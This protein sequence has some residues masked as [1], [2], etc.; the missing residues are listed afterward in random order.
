MT[1]D[2]R[3]VAAK[4]YDLQPSPFDGKDIPFYIALIPSPSSAV[5]E[6]GCGT[7]RVLVPLVSHGLYIHISPKRVRSR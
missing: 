6:L 2:I 4:F 5:L 1:V 7:G 3:A